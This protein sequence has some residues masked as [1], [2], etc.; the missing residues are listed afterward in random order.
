MFFAVHVM[1]LQ[2]IREITNDPGIVGEH[3]QGLIGRGILHRNS[4]LLVEQRWLFHDS[5]S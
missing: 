5:D 3:R 2:G 1:P 4:Q